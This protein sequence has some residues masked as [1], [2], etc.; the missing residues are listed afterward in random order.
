MTIIDVHS[1]YVPRGWPDLGEGM[2]RLEIASEREAIIMIGSR[3]FRRIGDNCWNADVRLADM[4]QDG[5]AYQ[6]VS[7]TPVF[8][9]YDLPGPEAER[10]S[11]IFND[12][13]L[14]ICE[15]ADPE[16]ER[17]PTVRE[18]DPQRIGNPIEAASEDHRHDRQV[19]LCGHA[20]Q[21]TRHP[22]IQPG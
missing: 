15:P 22:S 13:A 4:D 18:A 16:G 5:V 11:R 9:S 19:G 8:F 20:G 12:L 17:S 14:E 10:I 2:P 1:H 7:P 3:E 21:P 6:V